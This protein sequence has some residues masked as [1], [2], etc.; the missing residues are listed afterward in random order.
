M[1][2]THALK[3]LLEH[4]GLTRK[5][6][7]EITGWTAKQVHYSLAYLADLQVIVK[8]KKAWVLG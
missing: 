4:G 7:V 6:I 1:T 8:S 2:R 3:R 5:E